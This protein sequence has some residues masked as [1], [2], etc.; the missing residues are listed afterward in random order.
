M[1][2]LN[3]IW[4]ILLPSS[5]ANAKE[6][7]SKE[8]IDRMRSFL[9]TR[10]WTSFRSLKYNKEFTFSL[11]KKLVYCSSKKQEDDPPSTIAKAAPCQTFPGLL[12]TNHPNRFLCMEL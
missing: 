8:K 11:T 9:I 7:S 12:S 5:A 6:E 4:P 3:G 2:L 10:I 1:P